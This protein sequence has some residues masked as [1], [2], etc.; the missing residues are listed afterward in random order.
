MAPAPQVNCS[1]D[2]A[3]LSWDI[4]AEV[5]RCVGPGWQGN[6]WLG[7]QTLVAILLVSAVLAAVVVKVRPR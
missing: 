1:L 4:S 2:I 7:L 5:D 3:T 6:F